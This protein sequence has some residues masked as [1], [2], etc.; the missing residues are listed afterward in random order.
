M[1]GMPCLRLIALG[2]VK[3]PSATI[4]LVKGCINL[5]ATLDAWI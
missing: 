1:L 4:T 5:T 2:A 3:K